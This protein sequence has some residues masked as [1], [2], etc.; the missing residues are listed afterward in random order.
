MKYKLEKVN[1]PVCDSNQSRIYIENAKEL[2]FGLNEYFNVEEC[3]DCKLIYTNPR[4]TQDTMGAFYIDNQG[5]LAP[6]EDDNSFYNLKIV[7]GILAKYYNYEIPYVNNSLWLDIAFKFYKKRLQI[8]HTP[9]YKKDGIL[10]DIGCSSGNYLSK[11]KDLG[12]NVYG[13][14]TNKLAAENAQK[15]LKTNTI[16]NGSLMDLSFQNNFFDV[17]N[18]SMV[19]EHLYHP[20]KVLQ[21]INK[22]LKDDGQLII[23][24]P[25]IS[26]FEAKIYK[27]YYHGLHV[28][29]HLNHFSSRTITRLLSS[30]GFVVDKIIHQQGIRDFVVSAG[31]MKNKWLYKILNNI[32]IRK[33]VLKAVMIILSIIGKSSRM[34]IYARKTK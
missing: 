8:I 15:R 4:P 22:I 30:S 24:V 5:Y 34:T 10:L 2:Y 21:V 29:Q 23:S 31:N 13:V 33:F 32:I 18:M 11:M 27:R 17:I 7:Q 26:G 9:K 14:E 1:C 20:K 19:L 16:M 28:P 3:L 12:W 6:V 25:D